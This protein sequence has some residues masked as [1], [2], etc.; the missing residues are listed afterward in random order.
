MQGNAKEAASEKI[1]VSSG[2][3]IEVN[4]AGDIIQ[5]PVEDMQFMDGFYEL[6]DGFTEASNRVK[7]MKGSGTKEQL[8]VMIE[9]CKRITQEIDMLFGADCCK[10]VFGN[11]VPTPYAMADFFN[12]LLPIVGSYANERQSRIMQ[13]YQKNKKPQENTYVQNTYNNNRRKRRNHV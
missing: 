5:I 11:I 1:R 7:S 3:S 2:I 4:D 8:N 12:Q 9:E 13:K 10:K 6:I